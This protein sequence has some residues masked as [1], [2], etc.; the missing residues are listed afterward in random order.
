MARP[1]HTRFVLDVEDERDMHD[2]ELPDY[3]LTELP[4]YE[5]SSISVPTTQVRFRQV[6]SKLIT[7][8]SL[9]ENRQLMYRIVTKSSSKI[10]SSKPD[11]SLFLGADSSVFP[12]ASF[13]FDNSSALPWIPRAKVTVDVAGHG[14]EKVSM[15]AP[16]F[17]DWKLKCDDKRFVWTLQERPTSLALVDVSAGTVLARFTY[18]IYG[19]T[20]NKSAEIGDLAIFSPPGYSI[21]P[22]LIICSCTIVVK[23][24]ANM[25]RHHRQGNSTAGRYS[26][27]NGVT[28][29]GA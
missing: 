25:G 11:M 13:Q 17:A 5:R 27:G 14:S 24:W 6:K 7:L 23:Y 19:T 12:V 18:S 3:D 2:E 26:Y 4:T 20:A 29:T 21:G 16:N 9:D 28:L 1:V 10:F 15:E 8:E 22:E